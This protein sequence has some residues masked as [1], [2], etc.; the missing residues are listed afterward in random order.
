MLPD[1]V[2]LPYSLNEDTGRA[3]L[4]LSREM[5]DDFRPSM[6]DI[7]EV[8]I[9]AEWEE[10]PE[11]AVG[12]AG[13]IV[14]YETEGRAIGPARRDTAY[15]LEQLA[16]GSTA[17]R[18]KAVDELVRIGDAAAA[19]GLIEAA[20]DRAV[21][22]RRATVHALGG[23]LDHPSVPDTLAA[24]LQSDSDPMVRLSAL[25]GL[26][27]FDM[28]RA[29]EGIRTALGDK[30]FQVRRRAVSLLANMDLHDAMEELEVACRD[31]DEKIRRVAQAALEEQ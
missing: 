18:C 1:I 20:K 26:S 2:R 31:R 14:G 11:E 5:L 24:R 15:F 23:F 19:D 9:N 4:P 3:S 16:R 8:S 27:R 6:A 29:K 12:S 22:L 28:D 21:K 10:I 13:A 25:Q 17:Q 30:S 7:E